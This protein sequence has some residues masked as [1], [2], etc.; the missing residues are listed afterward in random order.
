MRPK[1]GETL[2]KWPG[3]Q[4]GGCGD[5]EDA[6]VVG[7]GGAGASGIL[8]PLGSLPTPALPKSWTQG[9]GGCAFL[10]QVRPTQ[11]G[12]QS[13]HLSSCWGSPGF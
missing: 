10:P 9:G 12:D 13:W 1:A 5:S 6:Q 4:L 2:E 8:L 11:P 3:V 7:S